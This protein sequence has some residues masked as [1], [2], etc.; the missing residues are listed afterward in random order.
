MRKILE[1]FL[2][3]LTAVGGFV[4]LGELTFAQ[5]AGARFGAEL[6]WVIWLGTLGIMLYGE[7]SGRIAAVTEQPVFHV[8]RLVSGVRLGLLT[9]VA[10]GLVNFM[11]CSA[12]IGGMAIL[13]RLAFGGSFRVWVLLVLLF[14]ILAAWFLPFKWIERVFG[15]LGLLMLTFVVSALLLKPDWHEVGRGL[16]PSLP[17]ASSGRDMLL[18]AFFVISFMS[19]IMLPYET[20]FYASGGIEDRWTPS[21]VPV[22]RTIIV[23]GFSLG[24]MV[25]A[26]L[27]MNGAL[28]FKPLDIEPQRVGTASLVADVTLGR[29]GWMAA[30][31]GMFFA[32]GGAALETCFSAAYGV[33]QYF[34]WPWGKFR[35]PAG[36]PRF[37][38]FW[39]LFFVLATVPMLL[40]V[41]PVQLVEYAIVFSVVILPFSYYSILK[42]AGDRRYL[43]NYAN[44]RWMN[45]F[46]WGYLILITLAGLA[47]IPL[48]ILTHGGKG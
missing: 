40:G 10:A 8:I 11:T 37:T 12:E 31:V 45:A 15:F 24:A 4:E 29:L 46:G 26:G 25:A 47:A 1:I 14:L 41:N 22:N 43:G 36:A 33:G 19:S 27:V 30:M 28:L 2:S 3:I 32:F 18:Y 17:T 23:I 7:M 21:D 35:R 34:G 9:L 42:A 38:L 20:Y 5:Q 39:M 44:G 13:L 48:L 16:V 6:L